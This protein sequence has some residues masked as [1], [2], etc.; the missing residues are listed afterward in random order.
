VNRSTRT[1][2][3][4][5][6][7]GAAC[8]CTGIAVAA[9]G[10]FVGAPDGDVTDAGASDAASREGAASGDG[11][12]VL[13]GA[14]PSTEAGADGGKIGMGGGSK[15]DAGY[16]ATHV[17]VTFC[18]DFDETPSTTTAPFGFASAKSSNGCTLITNPR[19]QSAPNA[20]LVTS[21]L[22]NG[23]R[24]SADNDFTVPSTITVEMD[25]QFLSLPGGTDPHVAPM[26]LELT[27]TDIEYSYFADSSG[28][29]FQVTGIDSSGKY[30]EEYTDG[31]PSPG[32]G[33]YHHLKFVIANAS[34]DGFLDTTEALH[35]GQSGPMPTTHRLPASSTARVHAGIAYLYD[36]Q[37]ATVLVDNV[38]VSVQ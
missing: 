6:L 35:N 14:T 23:T 3:S 32:T 8:A 36:Q 34:I 4:L 10:A 25:V 30:S 33:A 29:Y 27:G 28:S 1:A 7:G 9:C 5:L 26:S 12:S 16:C 38:T 18:D 11:A 21:S 24:C 22:G 17:P 31:L 2:I 37:S 15:G 19:G 13:D 20:L